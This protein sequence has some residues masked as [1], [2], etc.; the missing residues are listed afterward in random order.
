MR[1]EDQSALAFTLSVPK[2]LFWS[3]LLYLAWHWRSVPPVLLNGELPGPDDFLRLHQVETLISGQGWFDVKV[4]RLA[5]SDIHWSRIVDVPVALLALPFTLFV[6][7]T[8]SLRISALLWPFL[9]FLTALYLMVKTC[10]RL[11]GVQS[12]I[13]VLLFTGFNS[14]TMQEFAPGRVDH[15][16][17]QIVLLL[18]AAYGLFAREN[19]TRALCIGLAIPVSTAIGLEILILFIAVLAGLA[20][21]WVWGGK[22]DRDLLLKTGIVMGAVSLG[23]FLLTIP[24]DQYAVPYCDAYSIVYLVLLLGI[25]IGFAGLASATEK[26][27]S[28][29]TNPA[30]MRLISGSIVAGILAFGLLA[31]FPQCIAGPMGGLSEELVS[32]WLLNVTEARGIFETASLKP[33]RWISG[34]AY[35]GLMLAVATW[36]TL[37]RYRNHKHLL[38]LLAVLW[39]CALASIWQM[40]VLRTGIFSAIPFSVVFAMLMMETI[41]ARFGKMPALSS[42]LK[43]VLCLGLTSYAWALLAIPF[44][45]SPDVEAAQQ[46]N[47]GLTAENVDPEAKKLRTPG[48]CF[49]ASDFETLAKLPEGRVMS[50][51]SSAAPLLVHTPHS[52]ISGPYHRNGN[53]ILAV[54]DFFQSLPGDAQKLAS[55]ETIDYLAL[56]RAGSSIPV[57]SGDHLN[58]R[59]LRDELPDWLR[60]ESKPDARLMVLRVVR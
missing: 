15:H 3:A 41:S 8:A 23:L 45:Q 43:L 29:S 28:F 51:L 60:W 46:V 11:C 30:V 52:T 54:Y 38:T 24:P 27:D 18:L 16:N 12:R 34:V 19:W 39:V 7:L 1:A 44:S 59:I 22:E 56:C 32:R 58:A 36:V 14:F 9:L 37:R 55:R 35:L 42:A 21:A 48:A 53:Q 40:R 50:D 33:E 10:D 31:S 20:W 47:P 2:F 25:S 13:L 17:L 5:G 49:A 6:D 4:H 57:A 26:I